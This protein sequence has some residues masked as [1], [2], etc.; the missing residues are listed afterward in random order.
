MRR[1]H[2]AAG[3]RSSQS[4]HDRSLRISSDW[5]HRLYTQYVRTLEL[6]TRLHLRIINAGGLCLVS[7][8]HDRVGQVI[9][10]SRTRDYDR[11]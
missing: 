4:R 6:L 7:K 1:P 3:K 10:R 5:R 2:R 8:P 11:M 9:E